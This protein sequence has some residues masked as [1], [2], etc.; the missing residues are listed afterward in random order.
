MGRPRKPI[1]AATQEE[2]VSQITKK[3]RKRPDLIEMRSVHAES[4]DHSKYISH[5]MKMWTWERP[6]MTDPQ[7][8]SDRIAQ[9]FQLCANDDMKPSVEGLAV[10]F[11]TDRKTLWRWANGVESKGMPDE[12]RHV[13]K[14]AYSILNLQ[15]TDYMQNG[16]INPV[17]GIFLMKNNMGYADQSEVILTPNNPLAT[18]QTP[19]EIAE[20]YKQLPEE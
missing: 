17:A 18:D 7:A 12:V 2:A 3:R 10:A 9:Y 6:D 19:D 16:Q 5:S 1:Q 14:K 15:L 8:V 13:I 4:G 20:K 11:S